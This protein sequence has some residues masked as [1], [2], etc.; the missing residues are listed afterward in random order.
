[1]TRWKVHGERSL[2]E[3]EW[4]R[5]ALADVELTD[6]TRL[7]HYVI[8]IPFEVVSL[9]VSD[10]DGC[11]LLIWR[12]RFITKQWCWDVPA[13]RVA[14]GEAP[15][16]AAARA[17]IEETGWRPGAVRFLGEYHPTPGISDQRFGVYVANGA[18]C[19]A[20]PNP[21]EVERVEWVPLARVRKLLRDGQVD[22]LSLTSLLWA[23]EAGELAEPGTSPPRTDV[24][25]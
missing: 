8:R 7:D 3:S 22:G 12:Y 1:M 13:G 17:S 19:V 20:S 15:A 6:G 18:E 16:D 14:S 25:P 21:N 4:L 2:H 5:L 23:L 9:V 11:V 10:A 24:S